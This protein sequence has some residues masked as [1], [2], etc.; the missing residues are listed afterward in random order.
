MIS[1]IENVVGDNLCGRDYFFLL[2]CLCS[3][4]QNSSLVPDH[5]FSVSKIQI[6]I[7]N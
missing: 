6:I 3:T 5:A 4:Q 2:L 1:N 7:L